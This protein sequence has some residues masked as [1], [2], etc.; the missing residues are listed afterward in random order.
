MNIYKKRYIYKYKKKYKNINKYIYIYKYT[1]YKMYLLLQIG[2]GR[3]KIIGS[4]F[5]PLIKIH[6]LLSMLFG[7]RPTSY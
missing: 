3:Q 4:G 2:S 6:T 1:K 5:S 7:Y